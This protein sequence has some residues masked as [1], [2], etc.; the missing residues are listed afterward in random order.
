MCSRALSCR[1]E[2]FGPR[3]GWLRCSPVT[4]CTA[5]DGVEFFEKKIRPVLVEHC[6]RC[7]SVQ[8][9]KIKG[10]LRSTARRPAQGRRTGPGLVPGKPIESLLIKAVGYADPDS[11]AA[12]GEAAAGGR[13]GLGDVG[14][15]GRPDR[16][17]ATRTRRSPS[18]RPSRKAASSGRF[19]RCSE[20]APP[21]VK[22]AAWPR[23]TARPLRPR[24]KL[25]AK[26]LRPARTPTGHAAPPAALRP[27]RPAAD[28]GGDRRV[29]ERHPI[30][31]RAYREGSSTGCWPRRTS[32]SAGAGTGSTSPAT[33]SRSA[34]AASLRLQGRLALPRLRHRRVQRRQAV[35]PLRPRAD[36]RRPAAGRRR[37][38]S[39]TAAG[40]HG[41][42]RCSGRRTT[43][44]RTSRQLEMDVVDEQIDTRRQG[45]PRPDDRLRP[46]P[47]PQVRP[48]PDRATTTPWPASSRARKRIEHA[49]V[50]KWIERAAA[51]TPDRAKR[52]SRSTRHAVA[53]LASQAQDRARR[54]IAKSARRGT[55]TPRA[56]AAGETLPGIVVD[57]AQAKQVGDVEALDVHEARTSAT[58]T[59]TTT[60]AGKGEKTLTFQPEFPKRG[61]YEVRVSPTR[62][63]P[64]AP[65]NVA[66]AR[67]STPTARRRSTSTRRRRRRSTA[68]S[69]R[70]ASIASTK[71][72]Q[73]FVHGVERGH[74]RPRH[75]RRRAVP[76]VERR[77]S[78]PA[79]KT[80][81]SSKAAIADG[82][83]GQAS[84]KRELKTLAKRRPRDDR[85]R[86]RCRRRR[87]S[88]TRTSASAA[89][90][91]TRATVARAASCR[92]ATPA[93]CP[94]MPAKRERPARTG[95][96]AR[97]RPTIR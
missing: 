89:T 30:A 73:W 69:S 43:R 31:R 49:N 38:R 24:A 44:S 7:H 1:D 6:Y 23:T 41:V 40:R 81:R 14:G 56:P 27:D 75:R 47:R 36:R 11:H 58:A 52:R 76:A 74:Q 15:D 94:T 18:I 3:H 68:A 85:W 72:D 87:R 92:S 90:S 29:R 65:T 97:R 57:D 39:A 26:G 88:A 13:R 91:T 33:P 83:R 22:N 80:R 60:D 28:A 82:S 17:P 93:R 67:S 10:G 2:V 20:S 42:P 8:A 79:P 37:P 95:R 34:A 12:Q 4:R 5:Q 32:A 25:E 50:S 46:L 63:A 62:R 86:W 21:P 53:A 84:S 71:G 48:D 9:K 55:S 61:M 35:R 51:A 66:G 16:A 77:R 78:E 19:S 64:T 70:S 45:V 54:Q 96:V 59:S